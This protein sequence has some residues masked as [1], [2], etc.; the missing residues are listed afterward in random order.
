MTDPWPAANSCGTKADYFR[1]TVRNPRYN[2]DQLP[3]PDTTIT[4]YYD[5]DPKVVGPYLEAFPG[6]KAAKSLEADTVSLVNGQKSL[7]DAHRSVDS[8]VKTLLGMPGVGAPVPFGGNR[9]EVPP[10]PRRR[11]S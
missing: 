11:Y 9:G 4:H 2:F 3:L 5:A 1:K 6:V 10:A 8:A 7:R